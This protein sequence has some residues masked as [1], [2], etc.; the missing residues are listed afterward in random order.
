MDL[1]EK[2]NLTKHGSFTITL[3]NFF[4]TMAQFF[5]IKFLKKKSYKRIDFVM[6]KWFVDF[7]GFIQHLKH[8][9]LPQEIF[10]RDEDEAG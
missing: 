6:Y 5:E 9:G 10:M 3:Y 7:N 4:K 2:L 1:N 8:F